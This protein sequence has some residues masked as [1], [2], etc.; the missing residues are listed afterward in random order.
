M[1]TF[2][3]DWTE[4]YGE[5]ITVRAG[6]CFF[7][8]EYGRVIKPKKVE[9]LM[10]GF[11]WAL[12]QRP[13]VREREPGRY[14]ILDG[15]HRIEAVK[16]LFGVERDILVIQLL[17]VT[18]EE[19]AGFFRDFNGNRTNPNAVD[20]FRSEVTAR[21]KEAVELRH[22]FDSRHIKVVGLDASDWRG[23]T[24]R[25]WALGRVRQLYAEDPHVLIKT[26]DVLKEAWAADDPVTYQ[27]HCI[28]GVFLFLKAYIGDKL[29]NQPQL[30]K[31][32]KSHNSGQL[33]IGG[34]QFK[35]AFEEGSVNAHCGRVLVRWYNERR[36]DKN[37][38]DPSKVKIK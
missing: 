12:F 23:G 14:A 26:L 18:I 25:L 34:A 24:G 17:D 2:F 28:Q 33:K 32:M 13:V 15:N 36:A 37:K 27:T 8:S 30:V 31:K 29:F 5:E 10:D 9:R 3:R 4:Q 21:R 7:P 6:D 19:E 20:I 35:A 22:I 16:A 11:K 38:L 1:T